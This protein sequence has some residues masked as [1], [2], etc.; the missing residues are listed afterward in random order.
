MNVNIS[1]SGLEFGPFDETHIFQIEKSP[2]ANALGTG[3]K[4]VE[5]IVKRATKQGNAVW[6]IEAKSSIP[7]DATAFFGQIK[8]K[9]IHSLTLWLLALVKRHPGL[10]KDLPLAMRHAADAAIPCLLILVIPPMPSHALVGA[11]EKFRQVMGPDL[12][13]WNI[14]AQNVRVLNEEKARFYGLVA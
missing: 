11:S 6:L 12:R 1:E 10:H 13:L 7:R 2:A 4:K 3:I 9:M 14:G 8:T 5:F